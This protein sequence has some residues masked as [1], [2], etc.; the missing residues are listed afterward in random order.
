MAI[1]NIS[2]EITRP[3]VAKFC[4]EPS[5]AEGLNIC[6]NGPGHMTNMAAMVFNSISVIFRLWRGSNSVR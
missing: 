4:V 3:I 6:L 2:S 1:S 5:W